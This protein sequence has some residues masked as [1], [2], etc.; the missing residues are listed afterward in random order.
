MVLRRN[1]VDTV[2]VCHTQVA[3]MVA[4]VGGWAW[5]K[6][7]DFLPSTVLLSIVAVKPPSTV[8][9]N[10]IG[11]SGDSRCVFTVRSAY[12]LR[13]GEV[14]GGEHHLWKA[15]SQYRGLPRDCFE[16]RL[17]WSGVVKEDRLV[18]FLS[19]DFQSWL[20]PRLVR[21]EAPPE[22]LIKVNTTGLRHTRLGMAS[23]RGVGRDSES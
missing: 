15:V 23:C 12:C 11:W 2:Q 9:P 20:C 21:W 22:G 10:T 14:Q 17:L 1:D 18:E 4:L 7:Q 6:F 19:L 3:A 16:A 8:V 13:E 5:T